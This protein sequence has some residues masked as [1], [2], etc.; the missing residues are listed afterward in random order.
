MF[1]CNI[2][3]QSKIKKING[4]GFTLIETLVVISIIGVLASMIITSLLGARDKA[5]DMKRKAEISQ[6][7]RFLV[8]SCYSPDAGDGDY[9]LMPIAEELL[10]KNPQYG[11]YLKMIPRDPKS[12]SDAESGYRYIVGENGTKCAIYANLENENEPATLNIVVPTPKGGT[13]V[14]RASGNGPNGSPLY[15]QNSN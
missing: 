8:V 2:K 10:T 11:Q 15:Y 1:Y 9:D 12:G 6:I 13:G 4:A 3:K 5:R 14:F 7:G